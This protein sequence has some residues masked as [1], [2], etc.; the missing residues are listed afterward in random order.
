MTRGVITVEF[1][2]PT[3]F[4]IVLGILLSI[5]AVYLADHYL[6]WLI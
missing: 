4:A 3:A 6:N 1:I 2:L 5:S